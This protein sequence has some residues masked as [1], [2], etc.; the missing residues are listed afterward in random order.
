MGTV[1]VVSIVSC[2]N[3]DVESSSSGSSIRVLV[4][5]FLRLGNSGPVTDIDSIRGGLQLFPP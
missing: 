2:P 3:F 4:Q 5:E 1:K